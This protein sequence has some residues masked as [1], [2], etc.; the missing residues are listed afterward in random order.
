MT[1]PFLRRLTDAEARLV[2]RVCVW[3]VVLVMLWPL[4]DRLTALVS[5]WLHLATDPLAGVR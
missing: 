5:A 1:N 4:L 2:V 3:A